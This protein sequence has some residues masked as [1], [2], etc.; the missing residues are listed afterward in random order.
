MILTLESTTPMNVYIMAG[1]ESNPT[2]FLYDMAFLNTQS[3]K[4]NAENFDVLRNSTGYSVTTYTKSFDEPANTY[5]TNTVTYSYAGSYE[6][7]V[8]AGWITV[9]VL[10]TLLLLAL[11]GYSMYKCNN[12]FKAPVTKNE[13]SE[14][15]VL[16]KN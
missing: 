10:V 3:V 4:L 12:K 1:A 2:Q 14:E 16:L 7:S 8:S 6:E 11:L 5:L 15:S 9:L 13:P